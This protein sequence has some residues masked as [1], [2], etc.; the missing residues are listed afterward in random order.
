MLHIFILFFL[1]CIIGGLG[2]VVATPKMIL[3]ISGAGH[4]VVNGIF[5][6]Q[7]PTAIPI[8]FAKVCKK[9][10]WNTEETWKLLTDLKRPWY[11]KDDESYV[12]FN[13][14]DGKW[15]I[16]APQ[17][18][19]VYIAKESVANEV[20]PPIDGWDFLANEYAP[21]PLIEFTKDE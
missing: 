8:G 1:L 12:Y 2:L 6:P 4:S 7:N 10:F 9:Q 3:K 16:D 13:K 18:Y 21:L 5:K 14:Q 20:I 11:L 17:G 15:W 19:G